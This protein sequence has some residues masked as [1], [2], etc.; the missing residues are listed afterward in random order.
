MLAAI[1]SLTALGLVLGTSLGVA[2]RY[3][4][5]EG[6][7]LAEAVGEVLPGT[8]CGQCGLPGCQVAAE[9]LA[10]GE[11]PVD[12]CPPGGREVAARLAELLG[13]EVDLAAVTEKEP[14]LAFI[15]EDL[16]IGCARCF[17]KCP[18]D[19]IV[20]GPKQMHQVIADYCTGCEKC[21]DICPTECVEMHAPAPTLA[22]WHWP[23]PG[24]KP[25]E[26]LAA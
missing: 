21:V 26:D 7:P 14:A 19:A 22:T 4:R 16:C 6:N 17:Q 23:K 25:E 8:N 13:V 15:N 5:T 24:P 3:L 9:A 2:A 18:T 10:A 20:G 1:G 11:V 12:L